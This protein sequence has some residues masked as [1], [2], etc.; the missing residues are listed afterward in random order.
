MAQE[1]IRTSDGKSPATWWE[2]I[3]RTILSL[4]VS[5]LVFYLLR[6]SVSFMRD[7]TAPQRVLLQLYTTLGLDGA[8]A[9]LQE[10]GL[11]PLVGKFFIMLVALAVGV[12]GVW[13]LFAMANDLLDHLPAI[14]R[15]FFR[16]LI[17]VGPAVALLAV[18][19]IYPA[20]NTIYT[21]LSED[22]LSIPEVVAGSAGQIVHLYAARN[23]FCRS[24]R[25][26]ALCVR[27]AT[28]GS[29]TNRL[30]QCAGHAARY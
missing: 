8:A 3:L 18:Y 4:T 5:V 15:R 29:R 26:L 10:G 16:P 27:L 6:W 17:F 25:H 22:V 7:R 13:A 28:A 14:G 9:G 23:F 2:P 20:F 1:V 21:S 30:A 12:L 24:E 19:L 11:H